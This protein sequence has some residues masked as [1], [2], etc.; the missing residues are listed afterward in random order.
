MTERMTN[1]EAANHHHEGDMICIE[2]QY[3]CSCAGIVRIDMYRIVIHRQSLLLLPRLL[4]RHWTQ[5]F[6]ALDSTKSLN[7]TLSFKRPSPISL[8]F[9]FSNQLMQTVRTVH[10]MPSNDFG[11]APWHRRCFQLPFEVLGVLRR[12]CRASNVAPPAS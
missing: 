11:S 10:M 9:V 2:L 6:P 12:D 1:N 8:E 4:S 7:D 5:R 3:L